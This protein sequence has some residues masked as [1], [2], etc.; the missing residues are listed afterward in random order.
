MQPHSTLV[1]EGDEIADPHFDIDLGHADICVASKRYST[2]TTSWPDDQRR[3][4][5][6]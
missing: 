4:Q 2:A 6:A 1:F 5:R 3:V